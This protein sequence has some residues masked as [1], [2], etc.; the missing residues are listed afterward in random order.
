MQN[1]T[2][3]SYKMKKSGVCLNETKNLKTK[4]VLLRNSKKK[5]S[6]SIKNR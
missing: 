3:I 2:L 6:E 5:K 1:I 4:T